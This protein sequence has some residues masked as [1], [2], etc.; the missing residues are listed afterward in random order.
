MPR[1]AANLTMLFTEV[2]FLHR[3]AAAG[4][5]LGGLGTDVLPTEPPVDHLLIRAWRDDAPWLRDRLV[6]TPHTAYYS[7]KALYD[8]R[9]KAAE[10]IALFFEKNELRNH[11]V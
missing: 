10:T 5:Q 3:F 4:G 9:Y 8:M 1:F 11:I 6:I 7:E 2:P